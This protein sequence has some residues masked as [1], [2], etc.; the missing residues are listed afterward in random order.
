MEGANVLQASMQ[1]CTNEIHLSGVHCTRN[2]P[3]KYNDVYLPHTT[4]ISTNFGGDIPVSRV[5]NKMKIST[6]DPA[7][8]A[9]G[10]VGRKRSPSNA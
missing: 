4:E 10:G 2:Y 8:A 6:V 9:A 3:I 7:R 5:I 1:K